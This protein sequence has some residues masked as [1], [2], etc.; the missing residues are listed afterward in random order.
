MAG[1][2]RLSDR[3]KIVKVQDH[4]TAGTSAVTSDAIDTQGYGG[5]MV[6]TSF[7]TAATGNLLKLQQSSDN[8][9]S[10]DYSDLEGTSVTSGSSDED[11][12]LD[13]LRPMKRYVKCVATRGTSSTLESMWAILYN[14]DATPVDNTTT[15]TI[16]G[17]AHT[18]P[19]EGTA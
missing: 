3:I 1:N 10:D 18:S 11:V 19:A 17:E 6:I 12:W 15:G 7:G 14:P 13:L 9:G 5:V 4:T 16:A 2:H 8:A